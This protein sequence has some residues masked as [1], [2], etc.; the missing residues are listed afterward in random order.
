MGWPDGP[1]IMVGN[2]PENDALPAA[3]AGIHTYLLADRSCTG[4]VAG[5]IEPPH[6]RGEFG[7]ASGLA[8]GVFE[9]AASGQTIPD[10]MRWWLF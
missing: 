9:I 10:Q 4:Q 3:K 5:G 7:G 8:I 1:S 2:D 6:G